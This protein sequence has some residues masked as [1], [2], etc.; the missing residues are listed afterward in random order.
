VGYRV[1]K[2]CEGVDWN[3]AAELVEAVGWGVRDPE[4]M[5]RA[6]GKSRCAFV[7]HDELLVG[8][9]RCIGDDEYYATIWDVIIRPGYQQMGLGRKIMEALLN[10]VKE[11]QFIAL[12]STPGN[13]AFY[14]KLGFRLQKTAMV[15][16]NLPPEYP[17]EELQKLVE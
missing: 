8:M 7:Y 2:D 14:G 1:Q 3:A 12:T 11:R 6:F 4:Q 10:D 15:I 5:K 9:G 16:L 17:E 13:E